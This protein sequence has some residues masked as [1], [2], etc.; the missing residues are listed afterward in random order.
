MRRQLIA[1]PAGPTGLGARDFTG[2]FGV[3]LLVVISTFPVVIPFFF[4]DEPRTAL[5]AS[6]ALG[7][8]TLFVGGW[9]LGRYAGGSPWKSGL[10]LASIGATL[11]AV[12]M[13]LG[14]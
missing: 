5:R 13:A 1:A 7:L 12:I 14:G 2:A 6:N 9:M 10:G 11:V 3:F 8:A 4:I